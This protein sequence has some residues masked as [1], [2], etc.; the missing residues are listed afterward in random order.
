MKTKFTKIVATVSDRRCDVDFIKQL[1]ENGLNVVR[2]NSAHIQREGFQRI[3]NNVRAV[4]D[5]IGILMDTKGPEIRTTTNV[6]D[7]NLSFSAGDKVCVT[8]APDELSDKQNIHLS[9]PDIANDVKA[10]MHL[11][12]DDGEL[13]FLIDSIDGKT[14]RCTALNDGELGSRKSVNIPGASIKLP[15]LTQRDI[16][17]IGYAI[18]MG[19]D[20]I[21]HSFVRSKQD[22]LDI[23]AILDEYKSP[24]K[25]IAKIENQEGVDNI[26]EI[27]DYA[28]GVMVARGDLGIEI[29]AEK[30]PKIQRYIVKKC[31]ESKKP[32][33]IATQML[34]TMIEHPRP[35]RA[36]IS[37]IANAVY[38]GTDAIMLSGET[39]Y[40]AYPEEAVTVMR[41]VA[42]E[43]EGTVPPDAGRSLVRINNEITA[44]LARSAVKTAL[45][46][47]IKAIVVDT[48]SGRTARYLSAFRSDLPVYARCYNERVMRELALSFGVYPYYTEKPMSRDEF[49]NDLPEMLMQN[50]IKADDYVVVVGGSFGHGKGASFIEVCKIGEIR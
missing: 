24:I 46:L 28:Y 45:M 4:S 47:P 32:V 16:Q 38:M 7:E 12:I 26:D 18:E 19:V 31:I 1:A 5:R 50:G 14:L 40:G 25:I 2:M 13:D 34:H 15:S 33:I 42:E 17:N 41:E 39:A 21:A 6:D 11:L 9:Y 8:G 3:V 23:Q 36:E 43:N 48:L 44:A 27:L 37:D 35:T 22:V 10:G 49:M 20:F 30:I 29:E